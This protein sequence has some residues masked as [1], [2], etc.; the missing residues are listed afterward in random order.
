MI[1]LQDLPPSIHLQ[2]YIRKHQII[3]FKFGAIEA[4]PVKAYT[5]RPEICLVFNLRD[6]QV[7]SYNNGTLQKQTYKCTIH[8]QHTELTYRHVSQDFWSLQIVLQPTALYRLTGISPIALNNTFI[9]AEAIWGRQILNTHEEMNNL[10]DPFKA[11]PIAERFIEKIIKKT[12]SLRLG[13]DLVSQQML[14]QFT[15][16]PMEKLANNACLSVRQFH[17][18]FTEMIGVGPKMYDRIARF[19]K[20]TKLKNAQPH[21]DW[22]TLA[23]ELGYYDYQHL[24]RDFKEFTALTP[25]QFLIAEGKSPESSFGMVEV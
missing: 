9:D 14:T 5:P 3:R 1:I 6:T 13:V 8:G 7:I 22:L 12:N 16:V 20:V 4:I 25:N 23:L 17:R 2:P 19:E 11:I 10:D 18:L 15:P 21:K 24:V